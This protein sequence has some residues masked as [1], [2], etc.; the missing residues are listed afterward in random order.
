[1]LAITRRALAAGILA[2]GAG[3]LAAQ[4]PTTVR[5]SLD[6]K[7]QGVHGWYLL[8]QERGYFRDEGLNVVIDQG[9]GSAATIT[10]IMS[11]AY[12]AGFGDINAISQQAALNPGQQPVMV[13]QIYN[14]APFVLVTKKDG[15]IQ[16]V[17]DVEGRKL[18]GPPGSATLRLFPAFAKLNG[19]DADK[20]EYL[21][22]A[23]NLQ[24]Q[25]LIQGEVD[26]S[27]VFNV[28]SYINMVQQRQDPEAD[29]N[30]FNFADYGLDVYSNGVMVSQAMLR[31]K[32]EAVAGLVRAI[33]RAMVESLADPDL[34]VAAMMKIEPL[35]NADIEKLRVAYAMANLMLSDETTRLGLGD[36]DDARLARA[37]GVIAEA[38]ELPGK[39]A[40]GDV[41]TR[42]FLPPMAD[43]TAPVS[44]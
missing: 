35:L 25:M 14:R 31:D 19:I 3:G 21:N 6:F 4:E 2:L 22:F 32:P 26:G 34:A 37:I 15:P 17:A 11:G 23:P 33:N 42:A 28:T 36:L 7:Y 38:Y 40:P 12:D 16:S 27:L 39:P 5:F 9:E 41:F 43:R 13:Y 18:G 10:R 44:N 24:E 1:M 29:F 8:A 20:V 30:W